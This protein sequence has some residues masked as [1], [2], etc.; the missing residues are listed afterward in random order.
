MSYDAAGRQTRLTHPD[1]FF[2][3]YDYDVP[4]NV[5]AIREN[6]AASGAG[7]LASYSYDSLG[8]RSGVTFG[9]GT[10][11]SFGY[12]AA[13]RLTSLSSDLAGTARDQ[14]VTFGYNPANQIATTTRSNDAYAWREAY[15][16]DRLYSVDGLNRFLAAGGVNFGYDARGNLTS[17]GTLSYGYSAENRLVSAPGVT[18]GYDP[19]GRLAQVTASAG[20]TVTRFAYVGLQMVAEAGAS[21]TTPLRR[22]V[23]GPGLDSPI[24]W[25]EGADTCLPSPGA[26]AGGCNRRFLLA[27]ERGSI[28]S[29]ADSTGAVLAINTYDEFGIPASTNVGRFQFTGQAWL[30]EAG[31]FYYK[32]RMYSPTLGRFLQTDPIGYAD[33]LNWYTYVGGDP[34]NAVDPLGLA[35]DIV[36][37]SSCRGSSCDGDIYAKLRKYFDWLNSPGYRF[38]DPPSS[39]FD[40]DR[41]KLVP[42]RGDIVTCVGRSTTRGVGGNQARGDGALYSNYPETAG[43]S[44]R[45]G[46]FGT[47]A[48]QRGFLGLSTR[49]LRMYGTQIEITFS[50]QSRSAQLGGPSG[51]LTV[52]DY[53]DTNIQNTSG[54]AFD[55]YRFPTE[56]A[57]RAYGVQN[58]VTTISFPASSGGMCPIGFIRK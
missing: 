31:L 36:V 37:T 20:S 48:V 17:S 38:G 42:R 2:V 9:N 30:P 26:G 7:V 13:S 55:I 10:S 3:T 16:L 5:T 51:A 49:Q 47:V 39:P 27:D 52:S 34:V 22:Y 46:T 56:A 18:L 45:G 24:V 21:G 4:G 33:G 44:I 14:S 8:R 19:V 11:Q 54:V 40:G 12:D 1:G 6:G 57:G 23:Y 58:L 32:A 43:G 28:V 25:Y 41:A 50:D 15:S 35:G 29:V 53:G